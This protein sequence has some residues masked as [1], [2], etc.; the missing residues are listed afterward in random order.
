MSKYKMVLIGSTILLLLLSPQF[1]VKAEEINSNTIVDMANQGKSDFLMVDGSPNIYTKNIMTVPNSNEPLESEKTKP[2]ES[3][4]SA[5]QSSESEKTKPPESGANANQPS[6]S[7]KTKSSESESNV[8]QSTESEKS[9]VTESGSNTNQSVDFDKENEN[10]NVS[11]EEIE[12][13]SDNTE[14]NIIQSIDTNQFV[15]SDNNKNIEENNEISDE[16]GFNLIPS[17]AENK[18]SKQKRYDVL[19]V[20]PTKNINYDWQLSA[21][22]IVILTSIILTGIYGISILLPMVQTLIWINRKQT[23]LLSKMGNYKNYE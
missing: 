2:P 10:L 3:G 8:N 15:E 5:N 11:N 23:M 21:L 1:V 9:D 7:E 4:E 6:E 12:M 19:K 22:N 14:G 20:I 13:P 18:S 16:N 17:A